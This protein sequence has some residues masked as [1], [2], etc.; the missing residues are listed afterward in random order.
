MDYNF[1]RLES[2][3]WSWSTTLSV[4]SRWDRHWLQHC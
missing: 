2:P 1:V 3:G 4:W